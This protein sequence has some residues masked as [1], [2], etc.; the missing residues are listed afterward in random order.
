MEL[1]Q[2]FNV[3]RNI[4]PSHLER[5][6][7][8]Y[9]L[10]DKT[11]EEA[12]LFS[13]D[14]N[15]LNQILKRKDID[16]DG[17]VI[18]YPGKDIKRARLD[19]PLIKEDKEIKY[20]S[21]SGSKNSLYIPLLV[22]QL[23]DD[24]SHVLFF[25]E[26]EFKAL[27]AFQEGFPCIGLPGIWGFKSRG[28]LLDDFNLIEFRNREVIVVLDSDAKY[29]QNVHRAGVYFAIELSKLGAKTRTIT[30]PDMGEFNNE[31]RS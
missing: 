24:T 22:D 31:S 4:Y 8:N 29:N 7:T 28:E 23:L 25:T 6:R 13:A 16:S 5:L 1:A 21:P 17:I 10:N 15:M 9:G 18:P 26:G 3:N 30:L 12:K 2:K 20:L 19:K 11:I 27:K 14:S